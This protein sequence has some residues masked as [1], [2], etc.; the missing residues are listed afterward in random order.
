MFRTVQINKDNEKELGFKELYEKSFPYE[1]RVPYEELFKPPNNLV[2]DIK[3]FYVGDKFLGFFIAYQL[4]KY[5][6]PVYM[7]IDENMR[8]KGY[9]Q[10]ILTEILINYT[11]KNP[12]VGDVESIRQTDAPN[13][14]MRKRRHAFYNRIGIRDTGRYFTLS[15]VEYSIMTTSKEP[16]PDEDID[17]MFEILKPMT[18]KVPKNKE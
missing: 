6:Y 8:C 5:N 1:E 16:I 9:G 15:G 18:D 7:A 10:K 11:N 17:E 3:V 12:F 14:E 13:I 2:P 4:K